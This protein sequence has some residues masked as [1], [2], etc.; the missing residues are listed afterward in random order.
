MIRVDERDGRGG[1]DARLGDLRHELLR[2]R[3]DVLPQLLFGHALRILAENHAVAAESGDRRRQDDVR[4][5]GGL[6]DPAGKRK[7]ND[8]RAVEVAQIVLE[9]QA[10]TKSGLFAPAA[11]EPH[12]V[13]VSNRD[14]SGRQRLHSFRVYQVN[15]IIRFC[16]VKNMDREYFVN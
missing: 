4:R 16:S 8:V 15:I 11:V 13:D 7:G 9:N 5:L 10:G 2:Q 3:C 14:R 1:E 12:E 6:F